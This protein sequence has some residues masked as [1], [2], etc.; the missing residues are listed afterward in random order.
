[1]RAKLYE[2]YRKSDIFNTSSSID[3]NKTQ[4]RVTIPYLNSTFDSKN[5][6]LGTDKPKKNQKK[7]IINQK[8]YVSKHHQSDIFNLNNS[9][10]SKKSPKIKKQR[11]IPNNSTCF[12]SMKD[13]AQFAKDIKEYTLQSRAK[14]TVY[15]PVKYYNEMSAYQRLYSQ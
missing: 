5:P 12:D 9:V 10:D 8:K 14:K 1:M 4:I 7:I 15:N 11:N 13:N 6:I 3:N 2:K